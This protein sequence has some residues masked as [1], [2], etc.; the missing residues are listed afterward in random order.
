MRGDSMILYST[1]TP[2]FIPVSYLLRNEPFTPN[3]D[4][5]ER[6]RSPRSA[7]RAVDE[8]DLS[9]MTLAV[10]SCEEVA[11]SE[12]RL[13]RWFER[14][15]RDPFDELRSAESRLIKVVVEDEGGGVD[16]RSRSS[17]I[18]G[19]VMCCSMS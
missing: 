13:G 14:R 15:L 17:R 11:R 8:R 19:V 12:V 18:A 3:Y 1:N 10:F 2:V 4:A 7:D 6:P 16:S 9:W 5:P